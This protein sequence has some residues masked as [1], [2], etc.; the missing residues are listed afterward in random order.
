MNL[1]GVFAML[2]HLIRIVTVFSTAFSQAQG[3]SSGAL[4]QPTK[5]ALRGTGKIGSSLTNLSLGNNAA[6]PLSSL[7]SIRSNESSGGVASPSSPTHNNSISAPAHG[8][9]AP[10]QHA[11]P[12]LGNLSIV[13][14]GDSLTHGF[15]LPDEVGHPWVKHPYSQRLKEL[16]GPAATV[17]TLAVNVEEAPAP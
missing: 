13:A 9:A 16:M 12:P 4:S 14:L 17:T 3:S 2:I 8:L 15:V 7:V 10:S 6:N 1:E 5:L 11:L